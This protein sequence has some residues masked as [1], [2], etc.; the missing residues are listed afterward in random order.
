MSIIASWSEHIGCT[1]AVTKRAAWRDRH[2]CYIPA[3][4]P[5]T[6]PDLDHSWKCHRFTDQP[7]ELGKAV[8]FFAF[9]PDK[10]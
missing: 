10:S 7:T 1:A 9:L 6:F 8:T 5:V 2:I 3:G 4:K